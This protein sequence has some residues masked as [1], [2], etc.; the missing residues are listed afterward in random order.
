[1]R[2]LLSLEPAAVASNATLLAFRIYVGSFLVWGVWDNLFSSARM[3][4]FIN[5]V[6]QMNIFLPELMAPLSVYVQFL[7]GIA[8]TM[9]LLTRW[10][11]ILCAINFIVAVVMVDAQGGIRASFPAAMLVL[12]GLFMA[13]H[14]AGRLSFDTL[15]TS[16]IQKN[17]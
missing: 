8:F 10:A 9:G 2:N 6:R 4:D 1:M 15:I 11:G 14:G 16:R 17:A 13:T 3:D 7:C 5:F 12:F